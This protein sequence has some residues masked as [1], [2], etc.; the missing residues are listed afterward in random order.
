M[1]AYLRQ[2]HVP[3]AVWKFTPDSTLPGWPEARFVGLEPGALK[4]PK[5]F[6]E[7]LADLKQTLKQQRIVWLEG[8]HLPQEIEL[9]PAARGIRLAGR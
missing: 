3:L 1:S 8:R 4:V 6:K 2:L 7:A 9:S 5:P